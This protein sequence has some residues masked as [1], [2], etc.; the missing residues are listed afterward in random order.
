VCFR[1]G[2]FSWLTS[3]LYCNVLQLCTMFWVEIVHSLFGC[4][5]RWLC[6]PMCGA[7]LCV[8]VVCVFVY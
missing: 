3:V 2:L 6:V 1:L 5:L 7:V 4:Y 8:F